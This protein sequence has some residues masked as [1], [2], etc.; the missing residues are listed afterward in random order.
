MNEEQKRLARDVFDTFVTYSGLVSDVT[1]PDYWVQNGY[2]HGSCCFCFRFV[3]FYFVWC[4]FLFF[5]LLF[6]CSWFLTTFKPRFVTKGQEV[7]R[8][9]PRV[10]L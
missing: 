5:L 2:I 7:E 3:S 9:V 8:K 4:F 6:V 1:G 10:L